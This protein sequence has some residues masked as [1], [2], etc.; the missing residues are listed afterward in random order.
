[1]PVKT[2]EE[3]YYSFSCFYLQFL[4][5]Y[6]LDLVHLPSSAFLLSQFYLHILPLDG[7][8]LFFGF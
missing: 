7:G 3:Y 5:L 8:C 1:M 6:I 2:G 4:S